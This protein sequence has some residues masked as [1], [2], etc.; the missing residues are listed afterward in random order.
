[1]PL[2]C[3]QWHTSSGLHI[4]RAAEAPFEDAARPVRP[5]LH[6][7]TQRGGFDRLE[8]DAVEL[9]DS[10]AAAGDYF[11][12]SVSLSGNTAIIGADDDSH[13]GGADAGSAYV[14][15]LNCSIPGDLDGD[16]D[17][18]DFAVFQAAF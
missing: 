11:G 4:P 10:D 16:V 7:E 3:Q 6:V 5:E 13:A 12:R 9:V 14:F 8:R 15:D 18:A 17:L 1:M 2:L